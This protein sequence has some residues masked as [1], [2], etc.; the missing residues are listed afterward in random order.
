M[1]YVALT[2]GVMLALIGMVFGLANWQ[3]SYICAQ[4]ERITGQQTTWVFMDS[5]YVKHNGEWLR[6]SAYEQMIVARDG[7][8]DKDPSH[9]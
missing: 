9:D 6:Y 5:C 4:H 8:S 3:G 7:L 2:F 1:K